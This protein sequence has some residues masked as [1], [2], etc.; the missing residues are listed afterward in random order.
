M[1]KKQWFGK[2][3]VSITGGELNNSVRLALR[4]TLVL[5]AFGVLWVLLSNDLLSEL[6]PGKAE[7]S[8]YYIYVEWFYV[9]VTALLVYFLV[10]RLLDRQAV[11]EDE[12]RLSEA[13]LRLF[14][15]HA[16]VALAML[17]REMR[18]MA[19]SQQ[20]MTT[21]ELIGTDIIG[22]SF[23]EASSRIPGCWELLLRRG[24][25]GEA[26]QA[27][28]D[29]MEKQDGSLLWLRCGIRPW[30]AGDSSVGGIVIFSED[31]SR[32]KQAEEAV[33]KA[34]RNTA[35]CLK[36]HAMRCW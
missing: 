34:K 28:E 35:C 25:D 21:Y 15:E 31:I 7:L 14:I 26:L 33:A 5:A 13:R 17:D 12:L 29:C 16:P 3:G 20:W 8:R 30:Y 2:L 32:R 36:I 27:V 1:R 18:Y 24:L 6:A 19:V 9:L 10:K 22:K 11:I 4:L 23:G